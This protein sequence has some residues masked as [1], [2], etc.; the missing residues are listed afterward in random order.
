MNKINSV[1]TY[2]FDSD[3]TERVHGHI[4][5]YIEYNEAGNIIKAISYLPEGDIENKTISEYD[6][7]GKIIRE[8]EYIDETE[9]GEDSFFVRDDKGEILRIEKKFADGSEA[10]ITY[11]RSDDKKTLNMVNRDEEGNLE[12]REFIVFNAEGKMLVKEIYD[13]NDKLQEKYINEFNELGQLVKQTE[14]GK[15]EVFVLETELEYDDND[16]VIRQITYNRKHQITH[17]LLFSYDDKNRKIKQQVSN[18]YIIETI[19]ND[20]D[21]SRIEKKIGINGVVEHETK[22]KYDEHNNILEEDD[23][24]LFSRYD[25]KYY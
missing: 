8:S 9:I 14:L 20:E 21:N 25:Y 7:S 19:F 6:E 4:S 12:E 13:F 10:I 24:F 22:S 16:N 2:T 23:G 3:D 5:S 17:K 11:E 15:K 1:T 18:A